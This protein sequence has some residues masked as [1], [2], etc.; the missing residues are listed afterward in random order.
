MRFQRFGQHYL[1]NRS[2]IRFGSDYGY[3]LYHCHDGLLA[4]RS[5]PLAALA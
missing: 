4:G 5:V 1:V 2:L 3:L